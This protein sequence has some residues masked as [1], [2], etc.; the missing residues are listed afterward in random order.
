[1]C[2]RFDLN[3]DLTH[4]LHRVAVA[5]AGCECTDDSY[6]IIV[7]LKNLNSNRLKEVELRVE[8]L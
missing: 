3:L 4:L 1:M 8:E 5:V 7:S 2:T 6:L